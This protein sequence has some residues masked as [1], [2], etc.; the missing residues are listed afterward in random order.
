MGRFSRDG[1]WVRQLTVLSLGQLVGW[2][3]LFYSPLVA[4]GAIA[5]DNNWAV[6][7]ATALLSVSLTV[8][9]VAGI[10]VGRLLDR[11]SPRWVMAIGA[12]VGAIGCV[13]LALS[14]G[15]LWFTMALVMVGVS[16]SALLYQ[17][18]FT[19]VTKTYRR[20]R[21]M[22]LTVITI[23]GGLSS[24]IFAP[25]VVWLLRLLG[26]REVF[27]LFGGL[28][29]LLAVVLWWG[30]KIPPHSSGAVVLPEESVGVV[31]ALRQPRFWW[32]E[33]AMLVTTVAIFSATFLA[34]PIGM[35]KGLN[36]VQSAW[37]FA[38]IGFGQVFGRIAF[39]AV[40]IFRYP[41]AVLAGF[42]L[43]AGVGVG[44]FALAPGVMWW[45]VTVGV[46]VGALR[47]VHTLIQA[48]AVSSRW[49]SKHYGSINGFFQA[50]L[51]IGLALSP[52]V[53]SIVA[54]G[55]GSF[56]AMAVVMG[57][58]LLVCAPLARLT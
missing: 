28:M 32:L 11:F 55:M 46:V 4:I 19:V 57:V 45:L 41:R 13:S 27:V 50:P 33:L 10:G 29:V 1:G 21:Q 25:L 24:T 16:Q 40:D 31:A 43:S 12:V 52:A 54:T 34:I 9:A 20:R 6:G 17:A 18:A 7:F 47:G 53:G 56:S 51:S 39:L 14:S 42:S 5:G 22:A 36:D 26:W 49:G 44:V 3:V 2:G 37:V 38:A 58:V 15:L 30:L 48:S 35:E 23:A 8:A